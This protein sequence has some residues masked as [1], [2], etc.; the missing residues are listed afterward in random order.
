MLPRPRA[1]S[2]VAFADDGR[3]DAGIAHVV[4]HDPVMGGVEAGDD[5]VMVGKGEGG[6]DRPEPARTDPVGGEV[7]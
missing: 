7:A 6:G 4:A 5:G 3:I 1:D 2:A